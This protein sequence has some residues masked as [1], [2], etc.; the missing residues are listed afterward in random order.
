[1]NKLKPATVLLRIFDNRL[2]T[3][4]PHVSLVRTI[5][6]DDDDSDQIIEF[7]PCDFPKNNTANKAWP[8]MAAKANVQTLCAPPRSL[9]LR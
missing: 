7:D 2:I 3:L 8:H 5:T 1:M 6:P 9:C 4:V